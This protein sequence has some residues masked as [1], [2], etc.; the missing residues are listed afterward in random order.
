M[1]ERYLNEWFD[2]QFDGKPRR[3][4]C[5]DI[6]FEGELGPLFLMK[7]KYGKKFWMTRRELRENEANSK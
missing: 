5:I 4:K 6:E 1:S 7:T 2:L 3:A